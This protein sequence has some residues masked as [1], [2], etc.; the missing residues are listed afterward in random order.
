MT[1]RHR[2]SAA[3]LA[4]A[5]ALLVVYASLYPFEGWRWPPGRTARDLALLPE[6]IHHDAFDIWSN[7]LGYV[8]M[9][10]LLALA[11]LRSGWR[12][13]VAVPLAVL[14]AALLS[15]G[16]EWLQH[17]VPQ[18]V[19]TRG[20]FQ[21][22]VAGALGG[23]LLAWA[24]QAGG[25]VDRWGR[26]RRRWFAGDAAYALAL[27]VLW[28]L[29]LLFPAPAPLALG[30]AI[31]GGRAW[32]AEVLE[33]VSW[34]SSLQPLLQP[35][36]DGLL[37]M[38]PLAEFAATTLGLLAPCLV[39][40]VVTPRGW[41]RVGLALGALALGVAAMTLSTAL[42][43]G[44]HNA[45]AWLGPRTL[46]ALVAGLLLALA[47]ARLAP[48]LLCGLGLMALAALVAVV[49]Q[50]P[51]DPYLAQSLQG[52]EQGRFVRFHGLAQWLGWLWPWLAMAWLLARLG[53][54]PRAPG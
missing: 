37:Q 24:L 44:P 14:L 21:L 7:G 49:A 4:L 32:L 3:W 26:L 45:L 53:R 35:P 27:L 2:S 34:A 47:C 8:P 18:R 39:A 1:A 52:W 38:P 29:G 30:H 36:A 51:A 20:D 33:G 41:R 11:G 15:Y 23:A 28:P 13:R 25:L 16:C 42:N 31:D 54:P 12:Q 43:F 50:A 9:G 22:N 40:F 5:Y 6:A 48:R 46:L 10:L 17:F 19:P